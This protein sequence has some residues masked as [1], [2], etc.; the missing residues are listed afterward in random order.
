[1]K[2][3][4]SA[5]PAS[6]Q[7]IALRLIAGRVREIQAPLQF[8]ESMKVERQNMDPVPAY[9]SGRRR[10]C[11]AAFAACL[12]GLVAS[13]DAAERGFPYNSELMMDAKPMRGS[14]RVPMLVIGAQGEATIEGWC[15]RVKA[16]LVVAADTVTILT[17]SK[18]EEQCAPER[19]RADADLLAV[20]TEVTHWRRDA[21]VLTL[22]GPKTL[23]F[24]TMTN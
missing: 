24:R 23:R 2:G 11:V 17:G 4:L 6:M 7:R 10:L 16:Q 13:A 21:D 9:R 14:K 8:L 12:A 5:A 18:T 22:H 15:S 20:L 1:M 3:R 19:A